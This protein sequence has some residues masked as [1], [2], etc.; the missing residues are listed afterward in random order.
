[1]LAKLVPHFCI[2]SRRH[3]FHTEITALLARHTVSWKRENRHQLTLKNLIDAWCLA[4]E[5]FFRSPPSGGSIEDFSDKKVGLSD[6]AHLLGA[7][8]NHR[9]LSIEQAIIERAPALEP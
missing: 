8:E 2:A 3:I 6:D 1:V 5:Q 4:V 7:V 9:L